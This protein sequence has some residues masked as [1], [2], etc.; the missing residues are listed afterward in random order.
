MMTENFSTTDLQQL[1]Q[2]WKAWRSAHARRGR[3]PHLPEAAWKAAARLAQQH[4]V[5]RVARTLR[6]DYYRL[7]QR[8]IGPPRPIRA[9]ARPPELAT[10]PGFVEVPV[11]WPVPTGSVPGTCTVELSDERGNRMTVRLAQAGPEVMALARAFWR[12][13]R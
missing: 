12:R 10:S 4:G 5:S 6:V 8:T 2:Q 1:Q 3:R 7:R 13:R 11:P 9:T